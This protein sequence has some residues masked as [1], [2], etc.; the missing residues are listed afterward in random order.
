[1]GPRP[2][3]TLLDILRSTAEKIELNS[4]LPPDDPAVVEFKL[5][6]LRSIA[7]LEVAASSAETEV[8]SQ[9]NK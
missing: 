9:T 5:S 6:I 1:M 2:S 4:D 7:E 3:R 8:F